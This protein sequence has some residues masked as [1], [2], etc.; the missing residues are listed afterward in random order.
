MARIVSPP[1][2]RRVKCRS[3]GATIEY[4]PEEIE[5]YSGKD[6]SGGPDGYERIK[7]PPPGCPGHG[8]IKEW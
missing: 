7:C 3:C 2:P 4:L 1:E 6:F 5:R 8:Y